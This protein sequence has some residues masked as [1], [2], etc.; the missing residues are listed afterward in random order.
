MTTTFSW[1]HL[2]SERGC[3]Q[4][5]LHHDPAT[6]QSAL[7]VDGVPVPIVSAEGVELLGE[8]GDLMAGKAGPL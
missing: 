2:D 5:T 8:L 6:N 7:T 1:T 3:L 4:A